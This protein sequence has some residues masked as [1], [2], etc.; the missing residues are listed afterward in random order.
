[1]VMG[2]AKMS[3][4]NILLLIIYIVLSV[5]GLIL[6]KLGGTNHLQIAEHTI[7]ISVGIYTLWGM[8]CYIA[9]FIVYIIVLPRFDLSYI[10]PITTGAV[11]ALVIV[12]SLIV[13]KEKI[14]ITQ[15]IGICSVLFGIIMMN[16][17]K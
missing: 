9:S 11:F 4:I 16:L 1:M 5:T 14:S 2:G 3:L 15:W 6:V 7:H 10:S 17:K 12:T 8:L 13:L